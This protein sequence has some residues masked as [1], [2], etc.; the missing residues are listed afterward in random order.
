MIKK[1]TLFGQKSAHTRNNSCIS[2][3]QGYEKGYVLC[4][5]PFSRYL[6]QVTLELFTLR[7]L[8]YR[9]YEYPLL[10]NS[11]SEGSR[12]TSFSEVCYLYR[13]FKGCKSLGDGILGIH[14]I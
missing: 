10:I 12:K 2:A 13:I 7:K 11:E 5:I 14:P 9:F 3:K 8:R 6:Q 1:K 4:H